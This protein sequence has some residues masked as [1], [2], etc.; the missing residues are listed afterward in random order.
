MKKN[1]LLL[2]ILSFHMFGQ[3]FFQLV[4]GFLLQ[5]GIFQCNCV[6]TDDGIHRSTHFMTDPGKKSGFAFV[7][8]LS[9]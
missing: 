9:G 6:Q 8:F 4:P 2:R 5:I 3:N 1:I 7:G